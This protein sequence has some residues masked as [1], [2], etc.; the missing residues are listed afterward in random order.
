MWLKDVV[1]DSLLE[2]FNRRLREY[3]ITQMLNFLRFL[4]AVN[5]INDSKT[6]TF[7]QVCDVELRDFIGWYNYSKYIPNFKC[8][9]DII[10]NKLK[11]N[12]Y[13][14]DETR[15]T[16]IL[17]A[18]CRSNNI[19][20][21]KD[22]YITMSSE[23]ENWVN[24]INRF[25]DIVILA[26][27]M[28]QKLDICEISIQYD[29]NLYE[30]KD[31]K[32]F[33]KDSLDLLMKYNFADIDPD[34]DYIKPKA[35]IK[36]K[37]DDPWQ[38]VFYEYIMIELN[39]AQHYFP[40]RM[41]LNDICDSLSEIIRA[42]FNINIKF[43]PSDGNMILNNIEQIIEYFESKIPQYPDKIKDHLSILISMN[44]PKY[45]TYTITKLA[46]MAE[47]SKYNLRDLPIRPIIYG[48]YGATPLVQIPLEQIPE[49]Y[50]RLTQSYSGLHT[51]AS[52][53]DITF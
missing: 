45:D 24:T 50:A 8:L 7:E 16:T 47:L 17:S 26:I 52:K 1:D 36:H 13:D 9:W 40:I 46:K 31:I 48:E 49:Y 2:D 15:F 32:K 23:L 14:D 21:K 4:L 33:Y 19:N 3:I 35:H 51:N 38:Q 42:I 37:Y 27:G 43:N 28:S 39:N 20:T 10:F 34:S 5:E 41:S 53:R 44:R 25:E 29:W 12:D 30:D 11:H 6:I 22:L 18:Y